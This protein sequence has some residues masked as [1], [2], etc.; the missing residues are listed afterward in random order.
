MKENNSEC[1]DLEINKNS[2]NGTLL[3]TIKFKDYKDIKSQ[4]PTKK[5][6]DIDICSHINQYLR[7]DNINKNKEK[8]DIPP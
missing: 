1:K 2:F 5:N 4:L 6:Y 8:E 7:K 3:K